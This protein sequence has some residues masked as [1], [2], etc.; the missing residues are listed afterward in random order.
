MK[1]GGLLGDDPS[2]DSSDEV[3]ADF[4]AI[5]EIDLLKPFGFVYHGKH[6]G[7][8]D[9]P[10][11]LHTPHPCTFSTGF[12]KDFE[13]FVRDVETV[14]HVDVR[15]PAAGEGNDN[16]AKHVVCDE[17]IVGGKI[18]VLEEVGRGFEEMPPVH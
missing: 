2:Y 18:E 11:R 6:G 12:G 5:A 7:T 9:I 1:V 3:I 15:R 10:D 14:A 8:S 4:A 16:I 17:A 13:P